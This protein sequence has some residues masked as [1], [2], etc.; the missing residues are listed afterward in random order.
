MREIAIAPPWGN[1]IFLLSDCLIFT[2]QEIALLDNMYVVERCIVFCTRKKTNRKDFS[3]LCYYSILLPKL[4]K[5]GKKN[6]NFI[7][8]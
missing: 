3:N 6:Q 1:D 8:A 5:I 7:S 4:A 2:K